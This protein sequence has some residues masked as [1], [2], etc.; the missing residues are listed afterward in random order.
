MRIQIFKHNNNQ[1]IIKLR[2]LMIMKVFIE[3]ASSGTSSLF[4]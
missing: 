4:W 3:M 2:K 1:L